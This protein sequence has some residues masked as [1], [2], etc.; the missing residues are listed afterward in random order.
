MGK[1][2]I[3]QELMDI[4]GL[5]VKL[6]AFHSVA[7][8]T[9]ISQV[10]IFLLST[11]VSLFP[12]HDALMNIVSSFAEII[13]GL[14]GITL[15]GY[16]FFLSRMDG[17]ATADSSLDFVADSVKKWFKYLIFYIT[18]YVLMTLLTSGALMYLPELTEGD[19]KFYYRLFCNEFVGFLVGAIFL[20]LVYSILVI[21]PQCVEKEAQR[22]KKKLE[23]K[24]ATPGDPV[25]FLMLYARIRERCSGML[26][27]QLL[28]QLEGKGFLKV[29][30]LL[31]KANPDRKKLIQDLKLLCRYHSCVVNCAE[32]AVSQEMCQLARKVLLQLTPE[33]AES[34]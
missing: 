3:P 19:H 29:I 22:L 2:K 34:R 30:E 4:N 25:Q 11:K 27:K 9:L 13:A 6:M 23:G 1:K 32:L 14:Y 7:T 10:L 24:D 5:P 16:T 17:L 20:I 28:D 12:S 33:K 21:D 18:L 31:E 15:A 8:A 26:P